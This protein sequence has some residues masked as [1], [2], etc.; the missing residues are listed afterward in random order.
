ML[1]KQSEKIAY[2]LK[3]YP[4][5]SETFIVN[6]ILAH[7]AVGLNIEIYALY[8]TIDTHFQDLISQVKA[9]VKY[10]LTNKLRADD[11]WQTVEKASYIYPSIWEKLAIAKGEQA[12]EIYQA[13]LIALEA[14]IR[15]ITHF[16]AHFAT[17]AT[18]VARLASYFSGI[19]YTFTAH[20]KDIFHEYVR[21]D[22]FQRKLEDAKAVIT[23]SDYNL[24]YLQT[25]YGTAAKIVRRLYNGLDLSQFSFQQ[26]NDRPKKIVAVGRL[27]EKK[28]FT[29]LISACKI[30]AQKGCQF[31]CEIIGNG[32]LETELRSQ[33]EQDNLEAYVSLIGP[34]P[35][36]ELKQELQ[37]AAV[38]TAPC[39]IGKD[40]NRDG[41]PTVLL[42]AMALGTPCIS[43]DVTGIPEL[44]RDRDTGLLVAQEDPQ[45]LAIALEE[46]LNDSNLRVSLA[47]SA[48]KLIEREFD[49]QQNTIQLRQL[50]ELETTEKEVKR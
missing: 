24:H 21:Y 20:A 49:I 7:E 50:F 15:G 30:L 26:P 16:H 19:P 8:P 47:T 45:S 14:K 12:K 39:I 36:K 28:G 10:F 1:T 22:D 29:Y 31:T 17:S 48:R 34:R 37:Q 18:T 6:E 3:R 35:Q 2:I 9:P 5:Y 11:F 13:L 38:F 4:R 27:V 44:I 40:G 46:L 25:T 41:L 23:V 32:E 42:E 43:T 33:I